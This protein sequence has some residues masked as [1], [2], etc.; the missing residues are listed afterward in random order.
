[1]SETMQLIELIEGGDD[2]TAPSGVNQCTK[3]IAVA[4]VADI[5]PGYNI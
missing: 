4:A 5:L 3:Q 1:M 2:V